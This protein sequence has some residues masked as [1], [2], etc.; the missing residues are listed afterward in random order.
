MDALFLEN[1]LKL[2][3]E[4]VTQRGATIDSAFL[5]LPSA[6]QVNKFPAPTSFFLSRRLPRSSHPQSRG[7]VDSLV[8]YL[9]PIFLF[10]TSPKPSVARLSAPNHLTHSP[11]RFDIRVFVDYVHTNFEIAP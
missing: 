8:T 6:P 3:P 1:L 2:A 10:L 4:L 11:I 7:N 5:F 9:T